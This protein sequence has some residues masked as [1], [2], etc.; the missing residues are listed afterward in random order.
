SVSRTI[1][2]LAACVE[3]A[4]ILL[5]SSAALAAPQLV[6]VN[7][8]VFTADPAL[9]YAQA[10]AIEDGRILAVGGNDQIRALAGPNT[11]II[12]A[13]G[14]LVTPGLT[15]AHVHLGVGLPPPPLA[16]PGLPFP[17]PTAEQALAAVEQAAKTRTD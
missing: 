14:R 5:L 8:K 2:R 11:R 17:G 10:V 4:S 12:D 13:A 3:V 6:L 16:M 9:P 1:G 7:A 15:E